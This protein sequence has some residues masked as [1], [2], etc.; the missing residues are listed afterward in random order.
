LATI[1]VIVIH[2][3]GVENTARCLYHLQLQR[4]VNI[5]LV[6]IDNSIEGDAPKSTKEF[7]F[8]HIRTENKG[9]SHAN[10]KGLLYLQNRNVDAVF[11]LN[12]D[13][14]LE[15]DAL[16]T[17]WNSVQQASQGPTLGGALLMN[18]DGTKQ[19]LGGIWFPSK[20]TGK[21]FIEL[22]N[23]LGLIYPVGAALMMNRIAL[24][25][26]E[27]Q[28]CEDYFLY[29]EELDLV[30][31][32]DIYEHFTI[33][34]ESNARVIHLEGASAGSGH[35]H[36]DRSLFSEHHFHR[37]KALFYHRNFPEHELKMSILQVFV[38][39]KRMLKGDFRRAKVA[40]T[41]FFNN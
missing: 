40:W 10:N 26:I 38:C 37:S 6:L 20:G 16:F 23:E 12:N 36:H 34:L 7:N 14:F 25:Y 32:L 39:V 5:D 33:V 18:E 15:T 1:G 8:H 13:A 4:N 41:S 22:P 17:L 31:R 35:A 28:L 21:Q 11:L 3:S 2:Y 29:F 9:F 30:S 27:W 19:A 24:D